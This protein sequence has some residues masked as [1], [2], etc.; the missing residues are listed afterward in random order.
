QFQ[1][2]APVLRGGRFVKQLVAPF[3]GWSM[4]AALDPSQQDKFDEGLRES[5]DDILATIARTEPRSS[6]SPDP[7]TLQELAAAYER[8][9]AA[10]TTE[11]RLSLARAVDLR[12]S[13]LAEAARHVDAVGLKSSWTR[14]LTDLGATVQAGADQE[15]LVEVGV[16]RAQTIGMYYY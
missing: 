3:A 5:I 12:I 16:G 11:Q 2:A 9:W 4:W 7:A 8:A 14:A 6:P 13:L 10:V 15:L 1:V